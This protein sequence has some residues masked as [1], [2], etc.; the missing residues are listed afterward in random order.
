MALIKSRYKVTY[1][2]H[3][4]EDYAVFRAVDIESREKREYLLNVYEGGL[5]RRYAP[6]FDGLRHCPEFV[7]MF[8]DRGALVAVFT[9]TQAGSIDSMFYKGAA[10]DWRTR[11]DYAQM[12][13]HLLLRTSH[14]PPELCAAGFLS[15]NLMVLPKE[16]QLAV[17]YAV[18]PLEGMNAREVNYLLADQVKKVLL[19]R[20]TSLNRELALLDALAEA[21]DMPAA[22]LY[23]LWQDA[24]EA[25]T[26]EYARIYGKDVVQRSLF[27]FGTNVKRW[28]KKTFG[29]KR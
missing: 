16:G 17:N 1:V 29:K 15:K 21:R 24:R 18:F 20:Y 13:F 9:H 19:R 22:Q 26:A 3:V 11:L 10:L 27:F 28:M 4:Q 5:G 7:D 8:I 25:L 12:L 2:L 23:A 6:V 14:L